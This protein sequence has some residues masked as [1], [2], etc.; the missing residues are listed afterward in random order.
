MVFLSKFLVLA[1]VVNHP[2]MTTSESTSLTY[3]VSKT[4]TKQPRLFEQWLSNT[5]MKFLSGH[6]W[7][8]AVYEEWCNTLVR[9]HAKLW[10][11]SASLVST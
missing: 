10:R 11:L 1:E 2:F 9:F 5:K 6:T 4:L 7:H 8:R 3:D